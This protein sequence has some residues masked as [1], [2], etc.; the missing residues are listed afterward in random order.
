[1]QGKAGDVVNY[2]RGRGDANDD[3]AQFCTLVAEHEIELEDGSCCAGDGRRGEMNFEI[4][5][6]IPVDLI[7]SGLMILKSGVGIDG[8]PSSKL[9]A[10]QEPSDFTKPATPLSP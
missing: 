3:R 10:R 6:A 7:G 9:H 2:G 1:M 8:C 4:P 5:R